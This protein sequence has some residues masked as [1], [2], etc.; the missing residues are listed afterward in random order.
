MNKQI[1]KWTL[2]IVLTILLVIV[3]IHPEINF[4]TKSLFKPEILSVE[5]ESQLN[6]F[7][8]KEKRAQMDSIM[9]ISAASFGFNGSVL[10]ALNGQIVYSRSFG[11]ADFTSRE[12]LTDHSMYQL[13]SVSKQFTAMAIMILNEQGKLNYDD[14]LQQYL[15]DFPYKDITIRHLLNHTSGLPNYLWFFEK[16]WTDQ[17]QIPYNDALIRIL[18][19]QNLPLN[20]KPGSHFDY[21]NTGYAVLA[22]VVEKVSGMPFSDFLQY[23]IFE[24][25]GMLHTCIYSRAIQ[26][27]YPDKLNGYKRN[28]KSFRPVEE[29][30][31]DGIVGDKGVY[32]STTD[33]LLWD[34]ALETDKLISRFTMEEA[35]TPTR[36]DNGR[37][38][39]YGFGFRLK[40][41][42]DKRVVY[43]HGR[44]E[45]F[46]N[47]FERYIDDKFTVIILN[48][49]SFNGI[50]RLAD[51]LIQAYLNP[52]Y[53][54]LTQDLVFTTLHKGVKA[55]VKQ[56]EEKKAV[57]QYTR[58]DQ[59]KLLGVVKYL[60]DLNKHS[61]SKKIMQLYFS[62]SG[63]NQS[64]ASG[65]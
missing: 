14:P 26:K 19:E 22:Y 57:D 37:E 34:Q 64:K 7:F 60:D 55:A 62:L 41:K 3:F 54:S 8:L 15:P 65:S 13:A 63:E 51:H 1:Y 12:P 33:L 28:Y 43:H 5:E 50:N 29:T 11:Y 18:Q 2:R 30:L 4:G 25:L 40:N 38:I 48:H 23:T 49:T 32:S 24:P 46:R 59:V 27:D 17:T 10:L 31:L 39:P 61:L 9:N 44:W 45:G 35:Y 16:Y 58:V 21:S 52:P 56:F 47:V 6:E 20:F 36:L 53:N 42:N